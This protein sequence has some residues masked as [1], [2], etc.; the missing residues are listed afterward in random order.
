MQ[1]LEINKL[2]FDPTH[3]ETRISMSVLS[4]ILK[5]ADQDKSA[6]Q[7]NA[8]ISRLANQIPGPRL[9]MVAIGPDIDE[10]SSAWQLLVLG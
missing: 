7:L 6:S 3:H 10:W 8:G 5:L 4:G 2:V 1:A 9:L